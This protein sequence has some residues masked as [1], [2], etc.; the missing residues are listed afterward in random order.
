MRNILPVFLKDGY[1]VGHIKQYPPGTKTVYSNITP[2][3]AIRPDGG[4]GM[5]WFGLQYFLLEYLIGRF[6]EHFFALPRAEVVRQYKRRMDTYL[7]PGRVDAAHIGELHEN[8][9]LPLLI[10]ALPEGVLVPYGVPALTVRNTDDKF[11]WLTNMIET[12]MS[13]VLW[14]PCTSATTAR[15]FRLAFEH[16]AKET[17][18]PKDFVP[19]QGHD[20][21][22]RGMSGGED[23]AVSGAA[24][25]LFF[26][27]SDTLTAIDLLEMY[28]RADCEKELILGSVDATEH[29]VMCLGIATMGEL[30]TIRR[31][32][33][34]VSP[35]GI[36]SIVSDTLDLWQVLTE[37]V[38]SLKDVIMKRD[39]KLVIRP[40]SGDPVKIV[41]GDPD[42]PDGSPQRAGVVELLWNT[43]GGTTTVT[44]HRLLDS[45]VGVIYGDGISPVRRDAILAG[46]A[47]KGFASANIVLGMGSYT[48]QYVTRDN[49]GQAMKATA[50]VTADQGLIALF[51]DPVTD[52]G[53]KKS[54]RGLL[55]VEGESGNYRLIQNVTWEEEAGGCLEPVFCDSK[56][57]RTTTLSKVRTNAEATL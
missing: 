36:L 41:C 12:I 25:A 43:F 1:K 5:V 52:T 54:A 46:L 44:G 37:Y 32:L 13:A 47:D 27:G 21:S 16:W 28:Y 4:R 22:M 42:A 30:A 11:F 31:L 53:G 18:S 7:G 56:M 38:P 24:H 55:R 51:K 10:K 14:K 49:H 35:T 48:Y 26:T 6:N 45:H 17:G 8:G 23:G 33:T 2:R 34:E 9:F 50:A 3:Y 29:S 19:W 20:F 39:G 15:S 40:D 57:L